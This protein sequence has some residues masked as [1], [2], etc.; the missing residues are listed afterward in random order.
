MPENNQI[1]RV[2]VI[3]LIAILF[4]LGI[5][6]IKS[7]ISAILFGLIGAYIFSPVY[8]KVN[9]F[10]KLKNLSAIIITLLAILI[11]LLPIFFALPVIIRQIFDMYTLMQNTNVQQ[12]LSK[13]LSSTIAP[14]IAQKVSLSL[15]GFI[16]KIVNT[17]ANQ[18]ADIFSNIPSL[19]LNLALMIFVFFY[20]IRDKEKFEEYIRS[21]V[22]FSPQSQKELAQKYKDMTS[23]VI[24]GHIVVGIVQGLV[25][26]IGL[27][28]FGVPNVLTLTL[29]AILLSI[30]P[31]IGAWLVWLPVS[32]VLIASG[33]TF[34][35]I[36]LLI[37]GLIVISWIDNIIRPWFVSWKT[38]INSALVLVG[39]IGGFLEFGILGLVVGPLII[40][41][42]LLIFEMYKNKKF[43]LIFSEK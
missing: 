7:I 20:A 5:L 29:I 12:I 34:S 42:L 18:F 26:G 30:M 13:F 35:G 21:L 25:T 36:G 1:N 38:N 37:Y 8:E 28:I 2:I 24:Y 10:L 17:T 16:I 15:N 22:P 23:A 27:L 33:N 39:M 3:I 40:S 19:L 41:Y 14:D 32:L 4:I 11:I 6:I 43:D 9:K 31:I